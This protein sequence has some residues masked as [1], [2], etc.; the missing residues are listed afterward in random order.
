MST[1]TT[2]SLGSSRTRLVAAAAGLIAA[3]VIGSLALANANAVHATHGLPHGTILARGAFA[4]ATDVQFRTQIAGK[5]RVMNV[6]DSAEVIVQNVTIDPGATTGWHSHHGPVVVV[7]AAGT[8]TL[9]Q[10]DDPSCTPHVYPA[11]STFIDP[12][13]GNVHIARNEGTVGIQLLA[14]YFDVPAGAGPA[15]PHPNPGHCSGF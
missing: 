8:M 4:D 5:H 1:L 13:Q 3:V 11:G 6:H 2:Q 15:L 14:T 7:V 10:G 9:Y 12:G